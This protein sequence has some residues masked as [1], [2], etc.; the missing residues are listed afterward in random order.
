M[1]AHA[2]GKGSKYVHGKGFKKLI[3]AIPFKNK[4]EACKAEYQIKQLSKK[5]KLGWFKNKNVIPLK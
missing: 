5:N 1:N 2:K 3:F 4:S